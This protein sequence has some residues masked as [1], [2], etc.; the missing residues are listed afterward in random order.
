MTVEQPIIVNCNHI[1]VETANFSR[2]VQ[3]KHG[4]KKNDRLMGAEIGHKVSLNEL[5]F[6]CCQW[7]V[8]EQQLN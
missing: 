6:S 3:S 4:K 2:N 1:D 8:L 5:V 7:M